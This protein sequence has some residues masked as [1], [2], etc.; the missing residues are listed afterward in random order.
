[1]RSGPVHASLHY[2]RAM[3]RRRVALILAAMLLAPAA[4]ASPWNAMGPPRMHGGPQG[5]RIS[6]DQAVAKVERRFHA[7]AVKAQERR[8]GG[9]LVYRIRLLSEDG[10]VFEVSVDATTGQVE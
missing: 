5:E 3:V 6:L 4:V 2:N 9:R 1:M 8:E 7:R 10:R